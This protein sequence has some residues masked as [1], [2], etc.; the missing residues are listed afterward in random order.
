MFFE[1]L[2]WKPVLLG[3]KNAGKLWDPENLALK[4]ECAII[5]GS[6]EQEKQQNAH[7]GGKPE[8]QLSKQWRAPFVNFLFVL[9]NTRNHSTSLTSLSQFNTQLQ[10]K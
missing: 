6:E 1:T 9:E 4:C 3:G 7:A 10:I 8:R 5:T 2:E